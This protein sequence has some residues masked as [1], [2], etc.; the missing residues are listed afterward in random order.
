[1]KKSIFAK[2]AIDPEFDKKLN[3]YARLLVRRGLNVQKGETIELAIDVKNYLFA[4]KI[5]DQAYQAGAG[6]IRVRWT[7]DYLSHEKIA[8]SDMEVL[9]RNI[10]SDSLTGNDYAKNGLSI[11]LVLSEDPELYNDVDPEKL[12]TYFKERSVAN[13]IQNDL[14]H[15]GKNS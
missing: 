7:H 9:S 2:A 12:G 13:K 4:D 8:K 6:D 3:D 15:C 10:K 14:R 11:L 5:I 1:M